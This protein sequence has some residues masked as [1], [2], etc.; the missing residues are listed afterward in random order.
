MVFL[1]G[2]N[3]GEYA[4]NLAASQ[5]KMEIPQNIRTK[6]GSFSTPATQNR[7]TE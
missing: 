2:C 1:R 7:A 4:S 3:A 6:A 5:Q